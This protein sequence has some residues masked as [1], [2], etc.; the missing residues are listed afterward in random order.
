MA[1]IIADASEVS[2]SNI[3]IE[4]I[5]TA[6]RSVRK[7]SNRRPDVKAIYQNVSKNFASHLNEND[8]VSNIASMVVKNI[9]VNNPTLK[10]NSYFIVADSKTQQGDEISNDNQHKLFQQTTLRFDGNIPEK[11]VSSN[12]LDNIQESLSKNTTDLKA[13]FLVLKSFVMDEL[14]SI[15]V[16]L[17]RVQTKQCDQTRYLEENIKNMWDDIATKNMIIKMLSENLKKITN[18]FYNSNNSDLSTKRQQNPSFVYPEGND[19]KNSKL[20]S[21]NAFNR[22]LM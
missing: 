6:M 12:S 11:A 3:F 15:N 13:E 2:V 9:I 10:D 21:D 1:D 22:P 5:K 7:A 14:Y 4:Q 18:S 20:T 8:I 16:N 17:D 19:F